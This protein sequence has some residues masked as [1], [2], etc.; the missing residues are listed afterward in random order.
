MDFVPASPNGCAA[1][2]ATLPPETSAPLTNLIKLLNRH[3]PVA[4][5]ALLSHFAKMY[6]DEKRTQA[7]LTRDH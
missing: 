2:L 7:D 1:P 6:H 5:K 3:V 4:N